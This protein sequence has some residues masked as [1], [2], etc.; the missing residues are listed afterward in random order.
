MYHIRAE[1]YLKDEEADACRCWVTFTEPH[2]WE[3]DGTFKSDP[4][5]SPEATL[6]PITKGEVTLSC[7]CPQLR[8][9]GICKT[10]VLE[11]LFC[12][13]G[14]PDQ[15]VRKKVCYQSILCKKMYATNIL[16]EKYLK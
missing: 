14:A 8:R 13:S 1:S 6:Y 16:V 11:L 7:L 12:F 3:A 9:H 10:V 4:S 5:V 15:M 2:C